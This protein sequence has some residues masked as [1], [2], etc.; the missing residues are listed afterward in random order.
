MQYA[1]EWLMQ[2]LRQPARL[3]CGQAFWHTSHARLQV[4]GMELDMMTYKV[5]ANAAVAAT[6]AV[7]A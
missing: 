6:T 5:I 3:A 7:A 4:C 2:L 1:K